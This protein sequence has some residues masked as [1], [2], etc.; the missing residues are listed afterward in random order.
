MPHMAGGKFN[1]LMRGAARRRMMKKGKGNPGRGKKDAK[2]AARKKLKG[3]SP[4]KAAG[5]RY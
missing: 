5:A 3:N 1:E 4:S 2:K